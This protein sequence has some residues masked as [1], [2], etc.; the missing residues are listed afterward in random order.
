MRR[1]I[2]NDFKPGDLVYEAF[3]G[4]VTTIEACERVGRKCLAMEI[5][6]AYVDM[7]VRRWEA[8]TGRAAERLA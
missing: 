7:A 6:P 2:E 5:E 1:L 8:V 3:S 4:S